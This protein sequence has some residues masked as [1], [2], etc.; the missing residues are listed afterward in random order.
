MMPN[1]RKTKRITTPKAGLK[2]GEGA[3]PP[4]SWDD[5]GKRPTKE[6][7]VFGGAERTRNPNPKSDRVKP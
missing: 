1:R 5:K 6:E 4:A 2:P 7:D 3:P